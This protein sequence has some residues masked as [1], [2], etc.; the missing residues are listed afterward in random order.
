MNLDLFDRG[1]SAE[2]AVEQLRP[3]VVLLRGFALRDAGSCLD[4]VHG[5]ARR[6]PFRQMVTAGG[7]R[8]S[9]AMTNCGELGWISDETGYRY[10]SIDPASGEKWPPMPGCFSDLARDSAAA[11][12]FPEFHP[13][14]CLI[15]RYEVG[16][17]LSLHQDKDE[18][19]FGAPIVSVSLGVPAIFQLG[20]LRRSDRTLRVPVQHGDVL[21]WGG[22]ARL[23]YHGVMP[24]KRAH[25]AILGSH[26]LNLT[27]R[28]AG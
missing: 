6:A 17:R 2:C 3:G 15:N 12:D 24:L 28:K 26:R 16:S 7:F 27:L 4:A 9:V 19:D 10:D 1:R 13:D 5:V 20:G 23:L 22:C 11:A 21:V 8:M 14:A 18:R 25:H